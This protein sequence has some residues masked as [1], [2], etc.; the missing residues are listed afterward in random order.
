MGLLPVPRSKPDTRVL[1]GLGR[2]VDAGWVTPYQ[3]WC[4]TRGLAAPPQ[5]LQEATR[6]AE[7]VLTKFFAGDAT[8][9]A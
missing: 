8:T 6:C 9:L 4:P 7:V 3:L 5:P 1:R 2:L